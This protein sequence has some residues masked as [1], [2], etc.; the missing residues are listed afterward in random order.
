MSSGGFA[1]HVADGVAG[2]WNQQ[3]ERGAVAP[4]CSRVRS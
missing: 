2:A 4:G 3:M 1:V